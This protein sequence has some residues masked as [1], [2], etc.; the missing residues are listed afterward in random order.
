MC[1]DVLWYYV[2]QYVDGAM[3]CCMVCCAVLSCHV[4]WCYVVWFMWYSMWMVRCVVMCCC[5]VR[6]LCCHV[7]SCHV[8]WCGIMWYGR[9]YGVVKFVVSC[10]SVI[11]SEYEQVIA[12]HFYSFSWSVAELYTSL[13]FPKGNKTNQLKKTEMANL[14]EQ[15]KYLPS[16]EV[17]SSSMITTGCLATAF[18]LWRRK[19][20]WT[21]SPSWPCATSISCVETSRWV[22]LPKPRSCEF[23]PAQPSRVNDFLSS[24]TNPLSFYLFKYLITSFQYMPIENNEQ[25]I[26]VTRTEGIEYRGLLWVG[27][28]RRR[29]KVGRKRLQWVGNGRKVGRKRSQCVVNYPR[30][31]RK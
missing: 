28:G 10:C 15:R 17:T 8:L 23:L 26:A 13:Y 12:E 22:F 14:K 5:M 19:T 2:V 29:R 3:C 7:M 18:R 20:L 16:L 4:V 25:W 9:L 27:N 30:V 1:S 6:S 31:N 21:S 11:G 24:Q